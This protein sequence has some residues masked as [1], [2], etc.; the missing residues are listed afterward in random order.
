[1]GDELACLGARMRR[2]FGATRDAA[3]NGS[4]G[5]AYGFATHEMAGALMVV[6]LQ[7]VE[8]G[9]RGRHC[10]AACNVTLPR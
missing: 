7:T 8:A 4:A 6:P 10:A 2:S 9:L 3:A 5:Q 1:M